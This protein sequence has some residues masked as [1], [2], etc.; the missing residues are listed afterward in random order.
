ME[1]NITQK[2]IIEIKGLKKRYRMGVVTCKTLKADW[3][4]F[5][6]RKRG[7]PD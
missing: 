3:E 1:Q 2:P 7:L 5:W 6:A 4:S